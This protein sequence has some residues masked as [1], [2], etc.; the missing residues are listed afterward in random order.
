MKK[1]KFNPLERP[2]YVE[3]GAESADPSSARPELPPAQQ[4]LKIEVSRK[5]RKGKTVTVISGFQSSLET[6]EALAKQL[7]SQ[8]GSGG[9]VKDNTIEVQGDHREKAQ[10]ALISLGYKTKFSGG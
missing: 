4:Q 8:C 9:A 1:P 3:F 5:G 7:K 10:Q 6:L 2:A